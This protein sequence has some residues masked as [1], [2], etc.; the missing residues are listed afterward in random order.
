[1]ES[2]WICLDAIANSR[3]HKAKA[4]DLRSIFGKKP[5]KPIF[6]YQR[7]AFRDGCIKKIKLQSVNDSNLKWSKSIC[8]R[9]NDTLTQPYDR[10]WESFF[11]MSK[12][13]QIKILG[14]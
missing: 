1:M 8:Q 9:C 3:E 5:E 12:N 11:L 4:S 13:H 6:L 7:D 10:S 14:I 2:C